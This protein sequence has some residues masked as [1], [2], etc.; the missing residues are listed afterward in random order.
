MH[1]ARTTRT[2]GAERLRQF[3]QQALGA[4]HGAGQQVADAHRDRRRRRFAFFD[5]VEMRIEG[6]DLIDFGL[7]KL[8][9]GRQRRQMRARY[10]AV[11]VLD[12]MQMLDQKV[13]A[14]RAIGQERLDIRH[15]LRI[16]LAAFRGFAVAGAGRF[17]LRAAVFAAARSG[18]FLTFKAE[19]SLW[20]RAKALGA[21]INSHFLDRISDHTISYSDRWALAPAGGRPDRQQ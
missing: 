7:R 4:R 18:S 20:N 13:A 9:F 16:D 3:V 6:R 15:R 14:A 19:N 5:H 21:I 1:G 8:H 2:S 11:F 12:Q 17:G 10:V